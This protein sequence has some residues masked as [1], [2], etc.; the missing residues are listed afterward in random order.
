[1]YRAD[2]TAEKDHLVQ[3][4][5][6]GAARL[7]SE[8][9]RL[10]AAAPGQRIE[11][12]GGR[13]DVADLV[14]PLGSI[15]DY[16]IYVPLVE[17]QRLM[18][19][20]GQINL[21]LAFLCLEGTSLRG[22]SAV[23][24][25]QFAKLFP[26]FQVVTKTPI[27]RGR[28]LARATTEQYLS[29]FLLLVLAVVV[30]VIAVTGLQEMSERQ[31][32]VGILLAM[33]ANYAYLIALY[34]AKLLAIAVAASVTGFVV[35]SLLSQRLLAHVLVVHTRQISIVWRELPEVVGLTCLVTMVAAVL[36]MIRLVRTDPNAILAKE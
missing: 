14:E 35:G 6:A 12:L 24:E 32:E 2:E 36:P 1:V 18:N 3:P 21:I 10:L 7:G 13:F 20:P 8:A 4:V 25:Q 17:G 26:E 5:P 11:V 15:D 34:L 27:A 30:A 23:Q 16:R 19:R 29:R 28:Y 31:R 22:V 33:G 9:A